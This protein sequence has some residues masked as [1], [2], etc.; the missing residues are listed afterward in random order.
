[1]KAI[2][3]LLIAAGTCVG[4]LAMG[5]AATQ[6]IDTPTTTYLETTGP[7]MARFQQYTSSWGA[8]ADERRRLHRRVAR[9]E[10]PPVVHPSRRR[11]V[12]GNE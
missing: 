10:E 12:G 5:G 6:N 2:L 1:M 4:G 9:A 8:V 11:E 3:G 7:S